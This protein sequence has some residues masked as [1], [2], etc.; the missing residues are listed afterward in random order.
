M[1]AAAG[2]ERVDFEESA[3]LSRGQSDHAVYAT[4]ADALARRGAGGDLLLDVGCGG[5][6]LWQYLRGRYAR[7]V[8]VDLVRYEGLPAG[9]EYVRAE[10]NREPVPLADACA[11]AVVA[12]ET[13]EH[14]ENPRAFVRELA[15][16]VRPG[17]WVVVTTPNQQSFLS[18]LTL[19]L[20]GRF[21]AF[22]DASYPAHLT[23]LLEIDLRRI[24]AECGLTE[25]ET[26]YTCDGRVV[27]TRLHY[28]RAL[29][30]LTPRLCSDN[31]VLL[32]RRRA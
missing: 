17:G 32:A 7:C 22:Q 23:A 4:V 5:G 2:V 27:L 24:A 12:V 9:V 6:R 19:V 11:D 18:L 14:L 1:S 10:L 21:S 3:R 16:L 28:P 26:V 31:V 8:G 20:K 29:A 15:R 25:V 13:I 30:R